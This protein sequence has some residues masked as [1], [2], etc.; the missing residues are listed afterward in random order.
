MKNLLCITGFI[1]CFVAFGQEKTVMNEQFS[2]NSGGWPG[3]KT[4]VSSA[5]VNGGRGMYIL[6]YKESVDNFTVMKDIGLDTKRDFKF[7]ARLYKEKGVKNYGYGLTWGGR[8]DNYY[9]F[10]ISGTG[11][12]CYG[13][14]VDGAWVD[15][16]DWVYST[17]IS[18]GNKSY[19][20]VAV[21]KV[22]GH[23]DFEINNNVVATIAAD[24]FFGNL[25]GFNV[26]NAQ[27]ILVDWTT[28]SY[29]E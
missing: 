14:V 10:L 18:Q 21:R 4:A 25:I 12:Y 16:T 2:D 20:T 22:D 19:N 29:L 6:R 26:N 13:K 17:T 1:F 7:E 23:Y 11:Y 27:T 3:V 24:T 8:S 5:A 28:F 15:I 9:S